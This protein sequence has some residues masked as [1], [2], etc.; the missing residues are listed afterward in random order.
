MAESA[1]SSKNSGTS[2]CAYIINTKIIHQLHE[3]FHQSILLYFHYNVFGIVKHCLKPINSS[4]QE[5]LDYLQGHWTGGYLIKSA[6][7]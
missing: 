3:Q 7:N 1:A 4:E 5:V 6:I 2:C